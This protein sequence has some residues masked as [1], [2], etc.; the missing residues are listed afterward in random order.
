MSYSESADDESEKPEAAY[1]N[2][3]V[4]ETF[5]RAVL[6][7]PGV[8]EHHVIIEVNGFH[9]DTTHHGIL[10]GVEKVAIHLKLLRRIQG[11]WMELLQKV[12]L[13]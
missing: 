1:F 10:Q 5:R 3:K 12:K 8:E 13:S 11:S 6:E 4:E 2:K 7:V 9:A